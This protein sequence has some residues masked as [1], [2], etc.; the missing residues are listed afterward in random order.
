MYLRLASKPLSFCLSILLPWDHHT[1]FI[2][3]GGAGMEADP[4]QLLVLHSAI[5]RRYSAA[6][7]LCPSVW[8]LVLGFF[9]W[10]VLGVFETGFVCIAPAALDSVL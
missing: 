6:H 1:S 8:L 9:V 3:F 5:P 4:G 2:S 7:N 10:L